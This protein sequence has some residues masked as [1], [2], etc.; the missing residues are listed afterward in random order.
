MTAVHTL[1]TENSVFKILAD[2]AIFPFSFYQYGFI[3]AHKLLSVQ[4]KQREFTIAYAL[5]EKVVEQEIDFFQ[6]LRS[7]HWDRIPVVSQSGQ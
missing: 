1:Y 2:S 3:V 5:P 4:A 7:L 6:Q